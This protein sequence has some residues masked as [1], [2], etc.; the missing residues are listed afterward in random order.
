MKQAILAAED[1]R[2]Y[3]HTGSTTTGAAGSLLQPG[4]RRQDSRGFDDHD[5]G[6]AK[7]FPFPGKDA[8]PE[9]VRGTAGVQ[10]ETA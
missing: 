4:N 7:L 6:R 10:I 2:F 9:I 1:E 3:Q 8:D 5:A